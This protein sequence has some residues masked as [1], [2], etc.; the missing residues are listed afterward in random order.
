MSEKKKLTFLK[1]NS[2]KA[3]MEQW[4]ATGIEVMKSA[5]GTTKW[6]IIRGDEDITGALATKLQGASLEELSAKDLVVSAVRDADDE[7]AD[8]FYMLHERSKAE[9]AFTLTFS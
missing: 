6:F 5:D 8:A 4:N 2:A 9:S 7:K 1:T 3:F